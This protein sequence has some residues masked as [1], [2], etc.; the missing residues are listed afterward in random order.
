MA[1]VTFWSIGNEETGKSMSTAAVATELAANHNLKVLV[2]STAFENKDLEN[3][4]WDVSKDENIYVENDRNK[5][6]VD[7]GIDGLVKAILSNRTS[8]E[9]ITNYTKIIYKDRL[10]VLETTKSHKEIE[11]EKVKSVYPDM[12]AVANRYYDY[13]FVDLNKDCNDEFTKKVLSISSIIVMNITQRKESINSYM[14]FK[15]ENDLLNQ[16]NIITVVGRDDKFSKYNS[17]NLAKY[18]SEKEV[19]SIPYNTLFF[20]ACNEN[21]IAEFFLKFRKLNDMTDRNLSFV[22]DIRKISDAIIYKI[23]ELQMRA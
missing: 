6:N 16:N 23:Q 2:L 19:F 5:T 12:L 14:K 20:E 7:S 9:T 10:E 11:Y 8:P 18:L 21:N 15:E 4:F 17:K 13:I 3:C 22:A 1:I